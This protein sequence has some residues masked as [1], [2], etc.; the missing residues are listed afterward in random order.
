MPIEAFRIGGA[1]SDA[2]L[3]DAD[4]KWPRAYGVT[5]RG[6]VLVRPDG[7]VAW[8]TKGLSHVASPEETLASV[9]TYLLARQV[10]ACAA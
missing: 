5:S 3:Q 9:F 8:R 1:T 10:A 7:I 6:S 2:E 4:S